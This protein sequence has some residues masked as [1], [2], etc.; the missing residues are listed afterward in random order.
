M[1]TFVHPKY[2]QTVINKHK[3]AKNRAAATGA[4]TPSPFHQ[5]PAQ[6]LGLWPSSA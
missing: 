3:M 1:L 2:E 4:A 5:E 6:P